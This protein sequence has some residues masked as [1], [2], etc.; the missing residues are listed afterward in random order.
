MEEYQPEI[1]KM[2]AKR[3]Q[4][5]RQLKQ[6]KYVEPDLKSFCEN[7]LIINYDYIDDIKAD[8]EGAL[9]HGDTAIEIM[10]EMIEEAES[11][12]GEY[13]NLAHVWELLNEGKKKLHRLENYRDEF[14]D[15]GK[16]MSDLEYNMSLDLANVMRAQGDTIQSTGSM[17]IAA[18]AQTVRVRKFGE[19]DIKEKSK[20]GEQTVESSSNVDERI[21]QMV[22]IAKKEF[23]AG[24]SEVGITNNV[25]YNT[26]FYGREV[27]SED[28]KWYSWCS[29]FVT[30]CANEAG[31]LDGET[32]P[33]FEDLSSSAELPYYR[34]Y[35]VRDSYLNQGRYHFVS[36]EPDY[37]PKAG[38]FIVFNT[39]H[40][41]IVAGYDEETG[42]VY[43]YEGNASNK[44]LALKYDKSSSKIDGYCSNGGTMNKVF[45]NYDDFTEREIT[46][47]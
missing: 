3:E 10:E 2:M 14:V 33:L 20:V 24:V 5:G 31:L 36:D 25:K 15:F 4:I 18:I 13:V 39:S 6:N 7:E 41:G 16:K 12:A 47:R 46:T 22:E 40:I 29:V 44:V 21:I 23:D 35:N 26:W 42:V 45:P 43:T 9:F 11:C 1:E 30:W 8:V 32:L 27:S 28:G 38:D 37:I 17:G 19:G 34:V